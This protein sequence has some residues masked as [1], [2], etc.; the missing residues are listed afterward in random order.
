MTP[1]TKLCL[2]FVA[3]LAT[4]GA[5]CAQEAVLPG[6]TLFLCDGDVSVR[7]AFAPVAPDA[8]ATRTGEAAAMTWTLPGGDPVACAA[9]PGGAA[10]VGGTWRLARF[11]SSSD[12]VG[13][14]AADA[15]DRVTATFLANGRV[16]FRLDC[17][18]GAGTWRAEPSDAAGQ[19]LTFGPLAATRVACPPGSLGDRLAADLP[20][21]RSYTLQDGMLHLSLEADGGIWSWRR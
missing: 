1:T 9:V 8:E 3:A 15:P 17:N 18:R 19:S 7:A 5:V 14:F 4:A 10:L 11:Q 6:E 13:T 12:A 20:R 16:A 2:A 21:I